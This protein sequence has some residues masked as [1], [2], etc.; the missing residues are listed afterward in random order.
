MWCPLVPLIIGLL[1]TPISYY[2]HSNIIRY[3]DRPFA[4]VK[5]HD[6]ALIEN[7]NSLVKPGDI[8]IHIGDFVFFREAYL[9]MNI[10]R[11]LNGT[12]IVFRGNHDKYFHLQ[13]DGKK[14]SHYFREYHESG[15]GELKIGGEKIFFNHYPCISWNA[16]THGRIHLFGHRHSS[17][18][19]VVAHMPNSYDCG[20]DNNDYK[21]V[22]IE[23]AIRLAKSSDPGTLNLRSQPGLIEAEERRDK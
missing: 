2:S 15:Q 3:C 1:R 23:E 10:F 6:D 20:V 9:F 19:K 17:P 18:S 8:V 13:Y 4:N 12:F 22:H 5:E 14:L 16:S 7:H 11:R 21:P